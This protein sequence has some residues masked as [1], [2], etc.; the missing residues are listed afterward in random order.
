MTTDK[1][2]RHG[3]QLP[4]WVSSEFCVGQV[5][6]HRYLGFRGVIF[7]VDPVFANTDDWY[8]AIPPQFRPRKDQPFYHLYA[9]NDES[10]YTAY[11]SQQ[12]LEPDQEAGP[13]DHPEV[14]KMFE[15]FAEGGYKL[16]PF[17]SN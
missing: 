9:E 7:D 15:D 14:R 4:P 16:K 6:R 11:V 17:I 3:G 1:H 5:V 10:F 12:N 8:N 2:Q 13:V